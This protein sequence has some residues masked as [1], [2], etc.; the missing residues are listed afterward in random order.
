MSNEG[1]AEKKAH[2][3]EAPRVVLPGEPSAGF[4]DVS[5]KCFQ[6]IVSI[7][8]YICPVHLDLYAIKRSRSGQRK[9]GAL[10]KLPSTRVP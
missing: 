8:Q 10:G 1:S 3:Y 7:V 9:R 4:R 5:V 6:N 2:L